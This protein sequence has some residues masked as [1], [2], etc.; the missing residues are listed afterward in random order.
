MSPS[1]FTVWPATKASIKSLC[2]NGVIQEMSCGQRHPDWECNRPLPCPFLPS[3]GDKIAAKLIR[4]L[5][6]FW[7][8]LHQNSCIS[9]KDC[10]SS[11]TAQEWTLSRRDLWSCRFMREMPFGQDILLENVLDPSHVPFSHHGV[12]GNR[13]KVMPSSM[14]QLEP[15]DKEQGFSLGISVVKNGTNRAQ[16]GTGKMTTMTFRPP[17]LVK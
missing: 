1:P 16:A 6:L 11:S 9:V 2:M 3:Q 13:D 10:A 14:Q 15:I 4:V 7:V 8:C 5:V 17:T 12:I